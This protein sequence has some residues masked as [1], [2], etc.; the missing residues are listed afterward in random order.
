MFVPM[1]I[2]T[3]IIIGGG[4]GLLAGVVIKGTGFG[5]VGDIVIGIIGAFVGGVFM[6]LIGQNGFTGLNWWSLMVSFIGA[7]VL[8]SITRLLRGNR[9]SR[10]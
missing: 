8:L 2:L 4:A 5:I 9:V 1:N 7:V 10:A 6:N 3:W